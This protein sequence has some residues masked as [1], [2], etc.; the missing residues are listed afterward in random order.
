[1]HSRALFAFGG[2]ERDAGREAPAS[3]GAIDFVADLGFEDL[4]LAREGDR[5]LALLAINRAELD[6]DFEA[7]FGAFT[8]AVSRHRFHHL[9]FN[10]LCDLRDILVAAT[11]EVDNEYLVFVHFG[12]AFDGGGNRMSGLKGRNDALE[13][14]QFHEAIQGFL[15]GRIGVFNPLLVAQPGMFGPD[16]SVVEPGGNAVRQ[17]NL[18]I[19]VL[20]NIGLSSLQDTEGST[21]EA[22][23]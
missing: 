19:L 18:A 21:L 3:D 13:A 14:S 2:M 22:R 10:K 16:R 23:G 17:L 6:G 15:I 1:M 5:N 12:G 20:Q 11:G 7:V 4:Q 9:E 8:P